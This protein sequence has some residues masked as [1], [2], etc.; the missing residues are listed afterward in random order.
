LESGIGLRHT[1]LKEVP[2]MWISETESASFWLNV[3]TDIKAR[4]VKD[5][6]IAS[7]DNLS[8]IRQPIKSAFPNT[9]TQLCVVHQIHNSVKYV[10]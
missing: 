4:G 10:V 5:I 9:V 7:T 3:L 6:L 8:R 2:G 1:G